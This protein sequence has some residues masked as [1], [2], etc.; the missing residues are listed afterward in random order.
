VLTS[1]AQLITSRAP[2]ISS[3]LTFPSSQATGP[4]T[5]G[6]RI[7]L[8][9]ISPGNL[10]QVGAEFYIALENTADSD[11][12]VNLGQMEANGKVMFPTA[13]HL[14]LTDPAGQTRNLDFSD[15]YHG[16]AGRV[17]DFTVA[18]RSGSIYVLRLSLDQY[19]SPTTKEFAL[20]LGAGRHRIAARFE[21]QGARFM[22][23]DM[24]GAALLNFWKGTVSRMLCPSSSQS[25]VP[26][27]N[28]KESLIDRGPAN[29]ACS[30]RR[31]ARS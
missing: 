26:R 20:K 1:R 24:Q 5:R 9:S 28:Q 31:P 12:V 10:P 22:N 2:G 11:F 27:G 19:W 30:R 3:Q 17:D 7:K 14:T 25:E 21:G 4:T 15:R 8:S 18:L 13:I 6:L 16:M 29:T 23:L